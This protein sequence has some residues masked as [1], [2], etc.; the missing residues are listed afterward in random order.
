PE[1]VQLFIRCP[2]IFV[3]QFCGCRGRTAR[4]CKTWEAHLVLT[5]FNLRIDTWFPR[6][7]GASRQIP[8]IYHP[9]PLVICVDV[10]G[11][12]CRNCPAW[13]CPGSSSSSR[14][15]RANEQLKTNRN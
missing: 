5:V 6:T 2:R 13:G 3:G 11:G 12:R 7:C 4:Y 10:F 1:D 8:T 14:K 9:L 15:R